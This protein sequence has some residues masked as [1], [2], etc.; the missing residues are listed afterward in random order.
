M[1]PVVMRLIEY[2][3]TQQAAAK[4]LGVDQTTVS[5]WLRGKHSV[6]LANA[7]RVQVATLGLLQAVELCPSIAKLCP[8]LDQTI[9]LNPAADQ[10]AEDAGVLSSGADSSELAPLEALG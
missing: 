5:G 9:R 6:S 3:G 10:S 2:F 8:N 7:F 4:A 1:N